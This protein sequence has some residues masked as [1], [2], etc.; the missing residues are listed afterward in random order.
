MTASNSSPQILVVGSL[1]YDTIFTPAGAKHRILGGSANYFSVAAS[2]YAKV[3]VVGVVGEDYRDEDFAV[4]KNC[5]VDTSGIQICKGNTFHWEGRYE[6]D[7]N[8]AHTLETQLNVFAEFDPQIP[9]GHKF[10]P[11]VFLANIHPFLQQKV[12]S[13]VQKPKLVALDTMN[14]WIQSEKARL[15]SVIGSVQILFVNEGEARELTG[16]WN[17]LSALRALL[18]LGPQWV[19]VKRGEYGVM[20]GS[21][22]GDLAVAPGFPTDKVLDPTGAGD[23]FAGGFLGFLA[24]QNSFDWKTMKEALVRGSVTASFTVEDFGLAQLKSVKPAH[25][26]ERLDAYRKVLA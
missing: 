14:Y 21:R 5:Q 24:T 1:A 8:E 16:Q 26:T 18:K 22:D 12:L 15:Q 2:S 7:M 11:F 20:M 10:S 4:L 6:K 9:E 13:Q 19:V 23:S 3:A 25:L 17:V